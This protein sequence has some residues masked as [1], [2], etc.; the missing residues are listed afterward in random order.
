MLFLFSSSSF[1][2]FFQVEIFCLS[3]MEIISLYI[4]RTET[5][6]NDVEKGRVIGHSQKSLSSSWMTLYFITEGS[7]SF[8]VIEIQICEP[9]KIGLQQ[10]LILSFVNN[11]KND[12]LYYHM[13][14][15]LHCQEIIILNRY[16]LPTKYV[17]VGIGFVIKWPENI[18]KMNISVLQQTGFG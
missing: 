15:W 9:K 17:R 10:M 3:W 13:I 7:S 12:N 6:S 4:H 1:F 16:C 18:T 11:Q 14:F 2:F 5:I 8:L